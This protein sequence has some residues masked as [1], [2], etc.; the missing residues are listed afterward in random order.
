MRVL[1]AV[2][3]SSCLCGLIFLLR[4]SNDWFAFFVVLAMLVPQVKV[5]RNGDPL[6]LSSRYT[7]KFYAV[8]EVFGGN[9]DLKPGDM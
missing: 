2:D 3:L 5:V 7:F 8:R 4:K 6:V 9:G 1:Y